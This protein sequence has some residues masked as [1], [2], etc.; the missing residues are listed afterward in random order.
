MAKKTETML[1]EL[2]FTEEESRII[3]KTGSTRSSPAGTVVLGNSYTSEMIFIILEG[4]VTA[5]TLDLDGNEAL[6]AQYGTGEYF[7]GFEF[8]DIPLTTSFKALEPCNLLELR[9]R[10]LKVLLSQSSKSAKQVFEN[11][12]SGV[13]NQAHKLAEAI[14]QKRA[15][16]E[17][18]RAISDSPSDLSSLLGIV[19]ENAARLCNAKDAAILQ[20]EDDSLIMVAKFGPTQMWP[21]GAKKRLSRDWVTARSVIDC[22]PIHVLDLQAEEADYPDGALIARKYGHRT[23]LVVPLMREGVAIGAILIRRFEINPVT[24]KQKEL[25]MA[26]ADQASI[27]IEN[28]RLFNE[29]NEKSRKLKE[30][31][32]E[33][34]Q[35]NEKLE[36]RVAEQVSQLE[37]F[38]KLEHELKLASDIQKSML[39]RSTPQLDG[40]ELYAN[41]I[42]AKSVGGDFY[43][44]IPLG[45]D[46]LA[47]AI[48]DVAD[49]GIPA[50]LFMAMVRSFLRAEVRPKVS[51][52]KVLEAVN[53]HLLEL[54]DK[55]IFVTIL[56]GILNGP[57]NQFIY[58]RAGHELPILIDYKGS[59]KQLYKGKGQA[60]GIFDVVTLDE[61]IVDLS[62]NCMMVLYTDGISDAINQ[63]NKMFGLQGILR[64]ICQMP[65]QSVSQVCDEL[66]NAVA[67]HQSH[68]PQ[69]DDMTVV[70]VRANKGIT[71]H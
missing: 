28:V 33:L 35:W 56:L 24:Q 68:L 43:E 51:P 60:L 13:E 40:Y 15:I 3:V 39:P 2:G 32:V 50:A 23:V 12:L 31:S 46:S 44:F 66:F 61:Q 54:N 14:Q 18:L 27:A 53:S 9:M 59:V 55:G 7:G 5:F 19:A 49:K 20:V 21:I 41:M 6:L 70:G 16:T 29:I 36:Y 4:K 64:T 38:A 57:N 30:Q 63:K 34:A 62:D 65:N 45:N 10:D 69:F 71:A 52:K 42:P 37:Q 1:A 17:I 48:G 11:I 25:L 47:I 67:A 26:F 8:G 22:K 58:S